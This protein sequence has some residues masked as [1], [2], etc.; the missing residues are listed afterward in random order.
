MLEEVR[1]SWK[2]FQISEKL[3]SI[4]IGGQ[5]EES[6]LRQG[7]VGEK[8]K[9]SGMPGAKNYELTQKVDLKLWQILDLYMP[10]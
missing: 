1:G 7:T 6:I 2:S 5:G 4:F 10:C 3:S 9:E 8:W